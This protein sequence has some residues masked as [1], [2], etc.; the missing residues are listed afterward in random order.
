MLSFN[1]IK[2]LN[3]K[4][5]VIPLYKKIPAD[6]DTPVAAFMK[7]AL[8]KKNS[9]LLE[10]IEGG[11]KLAR[12]SFVGFDPFLML[13]G[14][15]NKVILIQD[16]HKKELETTPQDFIKELFAFYKPVHIQG[17]PRF[18]G[19]AVGFFSYDS[20]RWVE[21]IPDENHDA[22]QLPEMRFGLYKNIIAFDHLKQEI[23]VIANILHEAGE[24]GLKK[25]Y[26]EAVDAIQLSVERLQKN[27]PK[28]AKTENAK[29]KIK[30]DYTEKEYCGMVRKAKRYIKEGDV[31]QV[32][33]SQRWQVE[34]DKS[35]LSV[36]RSLRRINPS[37]Y[38]FLLNFNDT[39][40]IGSSPEMMVRVEKDV[41]ETRPIA[42]TRPRGKDD[43]EDEKQIADLLADKKELAEHTMLMDLGR[44]DIGRVSQPGSVKV[45][46]N[47]IIEKYS[48]VIHIVSSVIG[49]MTKK[50]KPVDGFFA[51]FPAGTVS[52]APKIRAMEIIDELEKEKRSVY[53]GSIAYLDFW[54]NLDSCIAIRTVIKKDKTYF[55]QA[56]AGIVADSK[57]L[58]EFKETEA[59]AKVLME[60][61]VG[62]K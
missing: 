34:S 44:N 17:L 12:Y 58:R 18:T 22:L 50:M 54:G 61:I 35:A 28:I 8:K 57:P 39:A 60:A 15:K 3:E 20:I 23:L 4:G 2:S 52:G 14:Y 53:A 30:P 59:K 46:D 48:H 9:F 10:S 51:C 33:L 56:G 32:V 26:T 37:P 7:L 62:D 42:G 40:V 31:F 45:K 16:K 27:L 11:E 47:M 5:N 55:I 38:M 13:E 6:L 29:A 36:Y 41:I 49:K 1:Q 21:N 25:K 43:A 24:S 19:G